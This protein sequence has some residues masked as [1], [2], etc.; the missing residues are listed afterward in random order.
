MCHF[1]Q[2]IF[3]S[4]SRSFGRSAERETRLGEIKIC[5]NRMLHSREIKLNQLKEI[6]LSAVKKRL[7]KGKESI[8]LWLCWLLKRGEKKGRELDNLRQISGVN[9]IVFL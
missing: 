9:L 7:F 4:Y 8:N 3:F 5:Y 6:T 1:V 2:L